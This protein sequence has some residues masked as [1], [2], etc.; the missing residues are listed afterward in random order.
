MNQDKR[1]R[2]N[3]VDITNK[4]LQILLCFDLNEHLNPFP[5]LPMVNG[6]DNGA[7]TDWIKIILQMPE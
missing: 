3:G 4:R 6:T 2:I 5:S 7:N 1:T